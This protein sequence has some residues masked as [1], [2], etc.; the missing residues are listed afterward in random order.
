MRQS[1]RAATQPIA[2][3]LS[4]PGSKSITNRALLLAA[5]AKGK[6]TLSGMLFSDDTR[7]FA[8]ALRQLGVAIEFDESTRMAEIT[9]CQGKF[10][11]VQSKVWC[12]DAG[13][14]ARF[15]VPACAAAGG[16]YH[17]DGS[18][19]LRKRPLAPLLASLTQQGAVVSAGQ[20]PLTMDSAGNLSGGVLTVDGRQSSQFTSGL[21]LAAPFFKNALTL[22]TS[23]VVSAPYVVMTG[24][25]MREFGAD[26]TWVDEECIRVGVESQYAG[27]HY[28][29][30]PDWSTASYF[31]AA[32]A[33]TGGSIRIDNM[34]RQS[35][36][37]DSQ[38]LTVLEQMGCV[39][40]ENPHSL[41][42]QGPA[43]LKGVS[44]NMRDFSDTFMTLAALACFADSPTTITHIG[45]TRLQE[46]DRIMAMG[47]NLQKLG[48]QVEEGGDW[49]RIFPG[50]PRAGVVDSFG[51]H[52][53]AMAC[54]LIG[55]RVSG[56]EINDASCVAK[57]CP[58]FFERWQTLSHAT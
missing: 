11:K 5:L 8:A 23:D 3:Q 29:V 10:P 56:I 19:Q 1:I 55:L 25:M 17:F 24:A 33:V 46:S 26:V 20:L 58:D 31:F 37:G 42:V 9:G 7:V 6:S 28:T 22:N 43:V 18:V 13:T 45:H 51:D 50:V 2:A 12:G 15:L 54:A 14:A 40:T 39:V 16:T 32:A 44:V 36:Q 53:I 57:T 52:R 21:L 49:L 27:R 38:F 4:L 41:Q 30:E 34:Q 48:V 35:L 47:K